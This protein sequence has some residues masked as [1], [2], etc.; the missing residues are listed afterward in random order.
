MLSPMSLQSAGEGGEEQES[1]EHEGERGL[2]CAQ[3]ATVIS[4]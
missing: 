2:G 4:E 3:N 1:N